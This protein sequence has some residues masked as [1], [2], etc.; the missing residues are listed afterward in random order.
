MSETTP[1][2]EKVANKLS[3]HLGDLSE[4]SYSALQL[5]P[6]PA[7]LKNLFFNEL[8]REAHEELRRF[9]SEK[10]L[11]GH[12]SLA[13]YRNALADAAAKLSVL[14][15]EDCLRLLKHSTC[16]T[17]EYLSRPQHFLSRYL[18]AES[19]ELKAE[20]ICTTLQLFTEYTYLTEVMQ[21]YI[22]KKKVESLSEERFEKLIADID[23]K[24]CATYSSA[25]WMHL[26]E[27]LYEFYVLGGEIKIPISELQIFLREKD[28][29]AALSL[30]TKLREHGIDALKKE[31]MIMVF[32][33]EIGPLLEK[34][35]VA[36][37]TQ[38]L[39]KTIISHLSQH[40]I[41]EALREPA[42][43]KVGASPLP[44]PED[45]TLLLQNI[46]PK[47]AHSPKE[48]S[49]EP[50]QALTESGSTEQIESAADVSSQLHLE[51][52]EQPAGKANN[53]EPMPNMP[54]AA[55]SAEIT[56]V[57]NAPEEKAVKA[58]QGSRSEEKLLAQSEQVTQ[59]PKQA[60]KSIHHSEPLALPIV[61]PVKVD[62]QRELRDLREMISLSDRKKIIKRIFKGNEEN[63]ER[64]I[65][66]LN[67]KKTWREASLYL[68]QEVFKRYNVDEYSMEAVRLTDTV[69][70][71]HFNKN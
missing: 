60:P 56:S 13:P 61:P 25:E 45:E 24:V 57:Q 47:V 66:A 22:A 21:Q 29:L 3:A 1:I 7:L 49:V 26:L 44:I 62:T 16:L 11:F 63:Y 46:F 4:F 18:Y 9:K 59:T 37:S 27:P 35:K 30:L 52:A 42:H 53:P 2:Y 12:S 28:A 17:Y 40:L 5:L 71:R 6:L 23:K 15:R 39:E 19:Y 55:S 38:E 31:D 33:G 14:P 65:T 67:Q 64:A 69:F 41:E 10:F 58:Q 70:E 54:L 34:K 8:R 48:S 68:D 43:T 20:T 32:E 51:A 50:V 36:K